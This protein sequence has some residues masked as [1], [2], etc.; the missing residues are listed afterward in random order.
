MSTTTGLEVHGLAVEGPAGTI[1]EP[2]SFSVP[3]GHTLAVIGE[4]GSG[5][6]MTARAL[7][8][9]LPRGTAARGI[10]TID[11]ERFNL[12]STSDSEW[13]R[14]RGRRAVLLLQD[15]FTSLSPVIRC[16]DQIAATIRARARQAGASTPARAALQREVTQRLD[17]VRLP[18]AVARKYP[19]ELS[20][21]MR[22]RVAIAAAL[23]AEPRLLIADEP[24]T[25][26]DA[27]TQGDVLDL[28]GELQRRHQM[29]LMLISHD[30]G[31]V[32]GR[33][34]QLLVMRHGVV[35]EAG[36]AAAVLGA[37]Q[38]DYTRA[39]L[40]A[41][42][43][44]GDAPPVAAAPGQVVLEATGLSKSFGA[45]QA[46]HD[47]SVT[48][49]AGEIVALVG[50]SGS[51]KSTFAR[52]IAGLD[53]PDTGSVQL[54]G[55]LLSSGRAGRK[56]GEMQIVFQDPY[57][58]LNPTFTVEQ[59][60]AEALHSAGRTASEVPDLLRLVELDPEFAGRRPAQLSGGQR[61]RVAIARALAPNPQLLIC[62]ESV[63]A[64]DVS[65]QAQIL[66]LL[67]RLRDELQ[68]A[69]LFITHDLGVVARLA[70]RAIVLQRGVIVESGDTSQVLRNP[71]HDYTRILV[72]AAERD[73]M[74][75]QATSPEL[76]AS[77]QPKD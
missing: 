41:N 32:A 14:V 76:P 47:A 8:G 71:Q 69:M 40:D 46:L 64:L 77:P 6:T 7:T 51:G 73:S 58:T 2:I 38:H 70:S 29:S 33:A 44:I 22:Q 52:C 43:T 53:R 66:D 37:P 62:D 13:A 11:G 24:T 1:V 63:S 27:S 39:L 4:S 17:E 23:A 26:L 48:V 56:P 61:Q 30:L 5:K 67:T 55:R 74:Y 35:V 45:T 42:P 15:P 18:A 31:V 49:A 68:L 59:A 12:A 9:L 19:S 72:R 16:G 25:A 28:L 34:D 54:G 3:A 50:E 65:V 75:R 60:L 57:S 10:A 21:G 20:G 36:A